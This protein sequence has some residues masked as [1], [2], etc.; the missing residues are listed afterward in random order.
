MYLENNM[1]IDL[2]ELITNSKEEI[3]ININIEYDESKT[4]DNSIRDLKSTTFNGKI[5][6]LCSGDFQITGNITGTMILPDDITLE[7]TEYNFNSYIE[8][9]FDENN[10]NYD[11]NLKIIQNKLDIS[12]FLWQSI[13]VEIPMKVTNSKNKDLTLQG[14]GW[15]LITEEELNKNNNS[16]FLK[17]KEEFTQE[18]SDD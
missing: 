17:L 18:R 13:I 15:R 8:E 2:T 4:N 10:S 5:T 6:K 7:D 1:N 3:S 9:K 14:N 16:P 11:N 12:D